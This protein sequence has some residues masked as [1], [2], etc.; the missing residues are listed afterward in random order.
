MSDDAAAQ[1]PPLHVELIEDPAALTELAPEW[2]AL[3]RAADAPAALPGWQLAWWRTLAPAGALVRA[4]VMR[5]GD[6]LVGLAPFFVTRSCGADRYRLLAASVTHGVEP[7]AAAGF[8]RDVAAWLPHALAGARPAPA[9]VSLDGVGETSPSLAALG[10]R[11][12]NGRKPWQFVRHAEPAPYVRLEQDSFEA[13]LASKSSNFRQQTRRFRRRL[14][15]AGGVVRLSSTPEEVARDVPALMEL[16]NRRWSGRGGSSLDEGITAMLAEAARGMADD[17]FRLWIVELDGRAVSAQLFLA[18][19][20]R[21]IY[22]NGGFDPAH[23]ELRPALLGVIAGLE[24]AF[25]RGGTVLDLGGGVQEYKQRLADG[26]TALTWA[27]VVPRGERYLR[28]RLALAPR[29]LEP[30]GRRVVGRLPDGARNRL[31]SLAGGRLSAV[32]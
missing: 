17:C 26:E 31:K 1:H 32:R 8:E 12:P 2:E 4:V 5:S 30:Y 19:G 25:D 16:H 18:A 14:E 28:G 23:A 22:W 15:R 11:W 7:L 29:Q 6:R 27:T 10:G 9:L 24:D 3:A 13:W 20:G 21:T